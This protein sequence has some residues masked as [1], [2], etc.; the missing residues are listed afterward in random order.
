VSDNGIGFQNHSSNQSGIGLKNLESR[1]ELI[2]G[3]ISI[4]T[5]NSGTTIFIKVPII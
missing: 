5:D 4:E 2:K 3:L 1:V